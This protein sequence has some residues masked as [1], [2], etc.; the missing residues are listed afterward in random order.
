MNLLTLVRLPKFTTLTVLTDE[1]TRTSEVLW[2]TKSAKI[3]PCCLGSYAFEQK[4]P[5]R[6]G[7][8][9]TLRRRFGG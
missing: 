7:S 3:A 9:V 5:K 1:Q 6:Q 8:H 2:A 4:N